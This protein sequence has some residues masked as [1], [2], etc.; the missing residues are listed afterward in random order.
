VK[1]ALESAETARNN[2]Q[3][4]RLVRASADSVEK[5]TLRR[6]YPMLETRYKDWPLEDTSPPS[7]RLWLDEDEMASAPTAVTA[8]GTALDI[9]KIF[10]RPDGRPPFDCLEVNL[11][12]ST[13]W[14]SGS[15]SQRTIAITGVF[16][17]QINDVPSSTLAAAIATAPAAG[18]TSQITI[19]ASWEIGVGSLLLVDSERLNVTGRSMVTTGQTLQSP[20]DD[21]L[22][23][24]VVQVTSGAAFTED[25]VILLDSEKMRIDEIAGNNLIVTRAWD[26]ST[27]ASHNGS[28]IYVPRLLTVERGA[29]GTT[30]ATHSNGATVSLFRPPD[31]I[32]QYCIA[33]AEVALLDESSAYARTI[34]AS[35]TQREAAGARLDRLEKKVLK[36]FYRVRD[37]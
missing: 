30:P 37:R 9:T 4:D 21:E 20:L 6:F 12:S 7:W 33:Y 11:G 17:Y 26:G 34:G 1:N 31:L 5:L 2:R 3:I 29:C 8:A 27:L 13:V 32:N 24:Q 23:A 15:T 19:G 28:A 10:A 35:D 25:E 22:S 36:G 16:G 14:A 18:T